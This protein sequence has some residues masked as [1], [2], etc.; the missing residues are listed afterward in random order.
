MAAITALQMIKA[1][2]MQW[3]PI[4][5]IWQVFCI[6]QLP[7][8]I[9]SFSWSCFYCCLAVS[10]IDTYG[11]EISIEVLLGGIERDASGKIYK[12]NVFHN[13]F[14]LETN[15]DPAEYAV[16]KSL[17]EQGAFGEQE[18]DLVI[19]KPNIPDALR[20]SC[21]RTTPY[22]TAFYFQCCALNDMVICCIAYELC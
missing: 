9:F 18:E 20:F 17:R 8:P 11:N 16:F 1:C 7:E 10:P 5:M 12:A 13:T 21:S 14:T 15:F 4:F 19:S 22:C 6:K 3:E 2:H